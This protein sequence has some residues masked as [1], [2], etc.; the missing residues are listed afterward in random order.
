MVSGYVAYRQGR[1]DDRVGR[2]VTSRLSIYICIYIYSATHIPGNPPYCSHSS[3]VQP[4]QVIFN[5]F[6]MCLKN[7]FLLIIDQN[8]HSHCCGYLLSIW[9][10]SI[11]VDLIMGLFEQLFYTNLWHFFNLKNIFSPNIFLF[12]LFFIFVS[13]F[14]LFPFLFPFIFSTFSSYFSFFILLFILPFF[15]LILS[16]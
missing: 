6:L 15:L 13:F 9:F 14:S 7:H 10:I 5:D 4:V 2:S 16:F 12:P 1:L 11:I 8:I 3:T